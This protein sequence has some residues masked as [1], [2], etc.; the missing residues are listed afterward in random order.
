MCVYCRVLATK[1]IGVVRVKLGE[2]VNY[3]IFSHTSIS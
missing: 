3:G 1:S 2:V